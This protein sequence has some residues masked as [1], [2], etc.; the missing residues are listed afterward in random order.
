MNNQ[1]AAFLLG[2]AAGIRSAT[3]LAAIARAQREG[4]LDVGRPWC[5]TGTKPSQKILTLGA[6]GELFADKLPFAP[7]RLQIRSLVV[8]A[9]TGA[10][11]GAT[12]GEAGGIGWKQGAALGAAGAIAGS[13]LGYGARRT[14]SSLA[15]KAGGRAG[16]G[17]GVAT[18]AVAAL[19]DAA[20]IGLSRWVLQTVEGTPALTTSASRP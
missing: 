10:F 5:Y 11:S 16:I 1:T 4:S 9:G 18:F 17:A 13:F 7:S 6:G 3:P 12:I 19:E 2:V 14:L 15:V 20:G 8:R